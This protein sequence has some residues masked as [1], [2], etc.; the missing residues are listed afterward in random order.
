MAIAHVQTGLGGST[1]VTSATVTLTTTT[2]NLL[3]AG[4]AINL[5]G[6]FTSVTDNKS[7]TFNQNS[8][9]PLTFSAVREVRQ[10]YAENITGGASHITTLTLSAGTDVTFY[11]SEFSGVAT[12]SS[13]DKAAAQA[14]VAVTSLTTGATATRTQAAELLVAVCSGTESVNWVSLTAGS[15]FTIPTNGKVTSNGVQPPS[16]VEYQIVAAT[17]TDA[18]T[19][20]TGASDSTGTIIGTFKGAGAAATGWGKIIA[21]ERNM[22]VLIR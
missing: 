16:G 7:N 17:G 21:G 3:V 6:R 15:G 11:V 18:G 19:F 13:F 14:Q 2:G 20:T 8:S 10:H 9:S 22:A 4:S 12:S 5:T 1:G